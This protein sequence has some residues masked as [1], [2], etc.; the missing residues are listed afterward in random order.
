MKII[1]T[2]CGPNKN[3]T[4]GQNVPFYHWIKQIKGR[5]LEDNGYMASLQYRIQFIYKHNEPKFKTQ[6][7]NYRVNEPSELEILKKYRNIDC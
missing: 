4:S 3:D 6:S 2:I 1:A 7:F 5:I